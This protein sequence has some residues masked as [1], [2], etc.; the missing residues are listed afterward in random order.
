MWCRIH[1]TMRHLDNQSYRNYQT[2]LR[3]PTDYNQLLSIP[4]YQNR[5]QVLL[6]ARSYLLVDTVGAV[7]EVVVELVKAKLSV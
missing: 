3:N 5:R 2:N 7:E 1:Y 4:N 6:L